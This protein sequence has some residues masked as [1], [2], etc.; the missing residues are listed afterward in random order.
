M[1]LQKS[2]MNVNKNSLIKNLTFDFFLFFIKY[3]FSDCFPGFFRLLLSFVN[4]YLIC[5]P[6]FYFSSEFILQLKPI[7][8]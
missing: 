4:I 6:S 7:A 5:Y 1:N 3:F 8:L 2:G